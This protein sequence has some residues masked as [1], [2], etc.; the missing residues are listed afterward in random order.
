MH[1]KQE[2]VI[3]S[4]RTVPGK[5][6]KLKISYILLILLLICAVAFTLYRLNL[7]KKLRARIEAIRAAGYP[8]TCEELD[9]WYSI[10]DTAENAAYVILDAFEYY[11]EPQDRDLLPIVGKAKL[12]ARTEP[13]PKEMGDLIAKYLSDNKQTLELL[14]EAA[15]LEHGRYPIDLSL[16]HETSLYHLADIRRCSFLLEL[17]AFYSA[18]NKRQD[19]VVQ[20]I[21]STFGVA[22]SLAEEPYTGSHHV[23]ISCQ[24]L[25]VSALERVINRTN[26]SD[27]QLAELSQVIASAQE[28]SDTGI[29]RALV[30]QRCYV[31]SIFQEPASLRGMKIGSHGQTIDVPVPILQAYKA[32]GLADM[33][34]IEY[35]DM[36]DEYIKAPQL[37]PH[38]RLKAVE[39]TESKILSISKSRI[40]LRTFA[41]A[42]KSLIKVDLRNLAELRTAQAAIAIQRYRLAKGELPDQLK[43]LVPDYLDSVPTDPFDGKEL[44]YKK[45][46]T[47]FVVYSIGEDLR[48]NGGIEMPPTSRE[49][50]KIPNWDITFFIER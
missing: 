16:G 46:D 47:G 40:L 29:S 6:R 25:A 5:K 22:C 38:L 26:L 10:P 27:E 18:E 28:R 24:W 44:R 33:D 50:R 34:T 32:L 19:I 8:V 1:E 12:P 30:G 9:K 41:P 13:L 14:H 20:S 49:R 37:P 36:M 21:K 3:E 48:D 7:K 43:D 45:L 17:E 35:L 31:L 23:R 2:D 39:A 15:V 42:F 11:Q 4:S